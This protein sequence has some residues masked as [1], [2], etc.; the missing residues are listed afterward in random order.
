MDF[1]ASALA[2]FVRHRRARLQDSKV[3]HQ[4]LA[5]ALGLTT[6]TVVEPIEAALLQLRIER[7]EIGN[8]RDRNQKVAPGIADQAFY[9]ALVVALARPTEAVQE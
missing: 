6:D 3:V 7:S 4:P 9:L 5:D 8:D 2:G 1:G